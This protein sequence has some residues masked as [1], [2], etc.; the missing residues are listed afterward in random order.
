VLPGLFRQLA[1][2][3]HD[4]PWRQRLVTILRLEAA[5]LLLVLVAASLLS[6]T[7]PPG[8]S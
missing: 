6:G 5:T 1:G 4:G 8:T 7:E 2:G 3:Q